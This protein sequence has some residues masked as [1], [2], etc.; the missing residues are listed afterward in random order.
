MVTDKFQFEIKKNIRLKLSKKESE[1]NKYL[2]DFLL[3]NICSWLIMNLEHMF[4][5]YILHRR[6]R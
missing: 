5:T 6:K 4:R 2:F 1:K 3:T